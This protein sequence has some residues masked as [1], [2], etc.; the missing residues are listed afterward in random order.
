MT[1]SRTLSPFTRAM[2]MLSLA[3]LGTAVVLVVVDLVRPTADTQLMRTT[4]IG[5]ALGA[6]A[7]S[8]FGALALARELSHRREIEKALMA[9]EAKFSGILSIAVDAIITVDEGQNIIHFNHGAEMLFGW[10]EEELL[11]APLDRLLPMR[12]RS[13]HGHHVQHFSRGPDVARRMGER[14]SIYGLKKDGTEFPAEASISR[15]DLPSGRLFTVVLRDMTARLHIEEDHRF[16]VRAGAMLA[17]TLDYES[18]LRSVVHLAI[19]HLADCCVLDISE[20]STTIRRIVSVHDDPA[21]TRLL[22]SLEER[23]IDVSD[24]PF[25]VAK[26]LASGEQVVREHMPRGWEAAEAPD[27][28]DNIHVDD[29]AALGIHGLISL[30]LVA[31]D[32]VLGVLTLL[33]TDPKRELGDEESTLATELTDR[34]AFAIDNAFLY[35]AAQQA[36]RARDEILGVVSHD[37]RNPLSAISMCAR[38]LFESPPAA[39]NE[40]RDLADAILESTQ[41]MQRLIQDLLDVSTI[42]SGHLRVYQRSEALLPLVDSVLTMVRDQAENRGILLQRNVATDLPNVNVDAMRVEQVLANLVSNSVKFTE[43]GGRVSVQAQLDGHHVI[44]RV[45]DTGGG[46]P[47][48]HLPRI[49]DRYWH[50]RRQSRTVGTGLGLAIARGIVEAH[51]GTIS[52]ESTLGVG[53]TFTFTLPVLDAPRA[54]PREPASL[55]ASPAL[56]QS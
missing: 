39:E 51:G 5:L 9:S 11:G 7:L 19:P 52:V 25:P 26:V 32:R 17:T 31:R 10:K 4:T 47:A 8:L 27:T 30:P 22:R 16:L 50:A 34:A 1:T 29:V 40:R 43:R 55:S 36:S 35:Q 45:S 38:V 2:L 56:S 15:L 28:S 24:W 54:T 12:F 44:V 14:R 6:A 3:I 48:E 18:T 46:I 13:A 42:E 49:F 23:R 53:T 41:L 21:R 33:A 37:L 20:S